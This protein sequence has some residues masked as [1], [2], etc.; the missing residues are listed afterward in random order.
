MPF[1]LR[2]ER[3]RGELL[4]V[5]EG[6]AL[7][8]VRI[9]PGLIFLKW[10]NIYVIAQILVKMQK[11]INHSHN[12][13][14][15]ELS[16]QFLNNNPFPHLIL[17]D[18]LPKE[19]FQQVKKAVAEIQFTKKTSDLFQFRQS[20]D[21]Q[22]I[23]KPLIQKLRTELIAA[24]PFFQTIT[25]TKIKP[26]TIDLA[27]S[28]YE[29]TD[30]LLCHDDRLENRAIAFIF[31]LSTLKK[32]QG[33]ALVLYDQKEKMT[34]RIIPTA[35]TLVLFKVSDKSLHEVEEVIQAKR[36]ALGGWYHGC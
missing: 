12:L 6:K 22:S 20:A 32:G 24:I 34:K 29:D 27:A 25:A 16:Q 4:Q 5:T 9:R 31:Y 19:I 11:F 35:N 2:P 8:S 14:A 26:N 36:I 18:F 10:Q 23:K 7:T 28:I 30:F 21:F 3:A 33:G 17:P 1:G 15:K 13:N